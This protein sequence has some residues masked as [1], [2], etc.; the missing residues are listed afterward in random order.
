MKRRVTFREFAL[1]PRRA[2][3]QAGTLGLLGLSLTDVAVWRARASESGTSTGKQAAEA[4][5]DQRIECGIF[6]PP[7]RRLDFVEPEMQD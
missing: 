2:V 4:L 5:R 6:F 3:L 7:G 1:V